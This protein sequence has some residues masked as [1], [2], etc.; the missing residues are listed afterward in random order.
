MEKRPFD[1]PEEYKKKKTSYVEAAWGPSFVCFSK[2]KFETPLTVEEMV[3]Y[4][5]TVHWS[6]KGI[7][8]YLDEEDLWLVF[9]YRKFSKVAKRSPKASIEVSG[10]KIEPAFVDV[11][12]KK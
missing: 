12:D 3:A 7:S 8:I 9:T 10:I 2:Q 4:L 11:L 5:E 6:D 1:V